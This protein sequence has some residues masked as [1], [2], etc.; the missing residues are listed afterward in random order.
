MVAQIQAHGELYQDQAFHDIEQ[1]FGPEFAYVNDRGSLS[2][3][4]AVLRAFNKLTP[5]IVWSRTYRY[6]RRREPGDD[7]GR[8]QY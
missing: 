4:A 2:I 5:D 1:M 8:M 3:D 7:P 6:W